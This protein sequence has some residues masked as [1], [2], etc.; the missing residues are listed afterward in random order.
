[1]ICLYMNVCFCVCVCVEMGAAE[2]DNSE[3]HASG[4]VTDLAFI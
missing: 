2:F 4:A 1:M 3:I